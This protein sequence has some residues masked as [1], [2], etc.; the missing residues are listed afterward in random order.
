MTDGDV[1]VLFASPVS[2]AMWVGAA[3]VVIVPQIMR[4]MRAAKKACRWSGLIQW[5]RGCCK[6]QQPAAGSEP[7]I[8]KGAFWAPFF[9]A[10]IAWMIAKSNTSFYSYL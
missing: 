2:I 8:A 3:A 6:G 4:R 7:E 5:R 9:V 10:E 1:A